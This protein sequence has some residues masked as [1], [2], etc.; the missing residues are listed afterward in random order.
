MGVSTHVVP[1][2]RLR[3]GRRWWATVRSIN[4]LA[5]LERADLVVSWMAKAHLYGAIAARRAGVPAVWYQHGIPSTRDPMDRLATTLPALSVLACSK[6][7][8][9]AQRRL[10]P[11]RPTDVAYPCVDLVRYDPGRLPTPAEARRRLGLPASGPLIG[12]VGRLQRWKGMHT[13]VEAMATILQRHPDAHCVI[14]GGRHDAEADYERELHRRVR[15]LGLAGHITLAGFQEDVP[16]WMQ[17]MDVFV[18]AADREPFGMVVV[19]AMALGKP[20][21]AGAAGGP[22]EVISE[23]ANG[24]LAPYADAEALAGQVSRFLDAPEQAEETGSRARVRAQDFSASAYADRFV[25]FLLNL[26]CGSKQRRSGPGTPE[27]QE[28]PRVS[29]EN[30]V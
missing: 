21:V 14:V 10:W 8:A 28:S 24:L 25:A 12:T 1:A 22:T 27:D 16:L 9:A 19:E 7:A 2:G 17:A 29:I 11:R 13:L 26:P 23:P 3:E 15:A 6:T 4:D 18:H 30:V 5:R 20:V